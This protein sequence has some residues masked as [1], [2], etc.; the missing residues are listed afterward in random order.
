MSTKSR[1][2]FI[3]RNKNTESAETYLAKACETYPSWS[4]LGL[5]DDGQI[6]YSQNHEGPASSAGI[7]NLIRMPDTID[8][9]IL[10]VLGKEESGTVVKEDDDNLQPFVLIEDGEGDDAVTKVIAFVDG[11]FEEYASNNEPQGRPFLFTK[12]RLLPFIYSTWNLCGG[13][14]DKFM[15]EIRKPHIEAMLLGMAGKDASIAIMTTASDKP[16]AYYTNT[17]NGDEYS[18]GFVNNTCEWEDK[19][20]M[21]GSQ[22][23]TETRGNK[24]KNTL[25]MGTAP[26]RDVG[27][28]TTSP[29]MYNF[30]VNANIIKNSDIRELYIKFHGKQPPNY[31]SRPAVSL[32]PDK[33]QEASKDSKVSLLVVAGTEPAKSTAAIVQPSATETA[34]QILSA[35]VKEKLK[36]F[37]DSNVLQ[38]MS[39]E[40]MS[41]NELP[42]P[43]FW[44]QTG[45]KLED[46]VNSKN[47]DEILEKLFNNAEYKTASKEL[48][49][50][51][52]YAIFRLNKDLEHATDPEKIE[53]K[54]VASPPP[55]KD[56]FKMRA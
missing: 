15:E 56:R 3:Y 1:A 6:T 43:T 2:L 19:T 36:K 44:D 25:K 49:R 33:Y 46:F 54:P 34:A 17:E 22:N 23:S 18:W 7:L 16:F 28:D 48:V 35:V 38:V 5:I 31:Q 29:V 12:H 13:N 26:V 32:L 37:V 11:P 51:L 27:K 41:K 45:W 50:D 55:G 39:P 9:D 10:I 30:R 21:S 47:R 14:A 20:P 42:L 53:A 24:T 8:K 4:G 40:E 52:C